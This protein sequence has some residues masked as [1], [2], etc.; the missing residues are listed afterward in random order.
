MD[1]KTW[2]TVKPEPGT[3]VII[4][5]NDGC[6]SAPALVLEKVGP[7]HAED[8]FELD[9]SFTKGAIWAALPY[10]YPIRFMEMTDADWY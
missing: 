5:C 6:S 4:V 2:D 1:W 9:D 3:K 7:L 10:D 8:G